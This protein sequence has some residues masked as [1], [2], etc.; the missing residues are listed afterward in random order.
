MRRKYSVEY[1]RVQKNK[2]P[3]HDIYESSSWVDFSAYLKA[4]LD[5]EDKVKV[6]E[7]KSEKS[8]NKSVRTYRR[9]TP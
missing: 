4:L 6:L 8:R 5:E 3:L 2:E 9:A 7:V 1:T